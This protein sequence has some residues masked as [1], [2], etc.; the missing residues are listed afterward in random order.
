MIC[1]HLTKLENIKK[2]KTKVRQVFD[3]A[4]NLNRLAEHQI[5]LG[6]GDPEFF[7]GFQ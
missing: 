4:K 7:I 2:R 6:I 5:V 3:A 1:Y